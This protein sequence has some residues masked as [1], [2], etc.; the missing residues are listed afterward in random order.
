MHHGWYNAG[1]GI[2]SSVRNYGRGVGVMSNAQIVMHHVKSITLV[3]RFKSNGNS[4]RIRIETEDG[5]ILDIQLYGNT[6]KLEMLPKH[7]DFYDADS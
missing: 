6:G 5:Q 3:A 1:I 4:R 2:C 7:K